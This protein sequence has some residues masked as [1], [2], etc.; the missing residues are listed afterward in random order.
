MA[1]IPGDPLLRHHIIVEE[2]HD[3]VRFH[4]TIRYSHFICNSHKYEVLV[5]T[6]VVNNNIQKRP[7]NFKHVVANRVWFCQKDAEAP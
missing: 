6:T 7:V 4:P 1:Q 3:M 5:A 2:V